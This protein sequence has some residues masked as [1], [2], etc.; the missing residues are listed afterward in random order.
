MR[1]GSWLA[2]LGSGCLCLAYSGNALAQDLLNVEMLQAYQDLNTDKN[3][4]L[5]GYDAGAYFTQN[6]TYSGTTKKITAKRP[7]Y[8]MCVA[9][10]TEVILEALNIYAK[11]HPQWTAQSVIP[12]DDWN[13][14]SWTTPTRHLFMHEYMVGYEPL[15]ELGLDDIPEELKVDFKSLI[16]RFNKFDS[17]ISMGQALVKLGLGEEVDFEK[18]VPGDIISFDRDKLS[19]NMVTEVVTDGGSPGH[20]AIFLAFIESTGGQLFEVPKYDSAKTIVGFKYF[21]A[22]GTAKVGEGGLSERRAFFKQRTNDKHVCPF[23]KGYDP[24]AG[25]P[26]YNKKGKENVV[27]F[28]KDALDD[29]NPEQ[30][31]DVPKRDCCV[32]RSGRYGPHGGRVWAPQKWTYAASKQK[33]VDEHKALLADRDAFLEALKEYDNEML[34]YAPTLS[35]VIANQEEIADEAG[36]GMVAF[37]GK[38]KDTL[39][40]NFESLDV[41]GGGI[42]HAGR[43]IDAKQAKAM[44]AALPKSMTTASK[45]YSASDVRKAWKKKINKVDNVPSSSQLA[46]E[47]HPTATLDGKVD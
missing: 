8:T 1:L 16:D 23:I 7:A 5:Q 34:A 10:V 31:P 3:R 36:S 19:K 24:F 38:L 47:Y 44:F 14:D 11:N 35:I 41:V 27:S 37:R 20:S 42:S 40:L 45:N 25:E 29:K 18:L 26:L 13:T 22:Q 46:A 17:R 39:S 28:C 33:L 6:L 12:V 2:A 30:S 4:R 9:A 32:Y 15:G 21:S 43:P